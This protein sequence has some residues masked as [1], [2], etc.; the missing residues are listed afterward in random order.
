MTITIELTQ[1]YFTYIDPIDAD[2][3][4][5][6]WSAKLSRNQKLRV[7]AHRSEYLGGGRKNQKS[8][9]I[10][11]HREIMSR[12]LGRAL[13]SSEEVDHINDNSLD[14][15]REN[16]RLATHSQNNWNRSTYKSNTSGF[17]GVGL[18]KGRWRARIQCNGKQEQLGYFDT[19]ELDHEAYC[20]AAADLHGEF[21][22]T[23]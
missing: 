6:E 15:R 8:K 22:R 2:L 23:A 11:L 14:N 4:D 20:K 13:L 19:P 5:F 21:A 3:A 16:L 12:I 17:K 10:T 7:Y 1:G 9:Y 18:H